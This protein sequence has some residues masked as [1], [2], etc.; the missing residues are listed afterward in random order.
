MLAKARAIG[1]GMAGWRGFHPRHYRSWTG[2][3]RA[4]AGRIGV[5]KKKHAQCR[6]GNKKGLRRARRRLSKALIRG[7][8]SE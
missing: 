8:L 3:A 2:K 5:E 4:Q 6:W 7:E 1:G